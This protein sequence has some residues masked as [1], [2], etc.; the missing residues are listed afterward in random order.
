MYDVSFAFR[1][2]KLSNSDQGQTWR[3]GFNGAIINYSAVNVVITRTT[4]K[5]RCRF[6]RL[7]KVSCNLHVLA[8]PDP[9]LV[10]KASRTHNT[11]PRV[12]DWVRQSLSP[13]QRRGR[14]E[15]ARSTARGRAPMKQRER[16]SER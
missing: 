4:Y 3:A 1:P 5:R 14:E 10:L 6:S 15:A 7:Y 16:A 12:K 9:E 2:F 8:V 13:W 11:Q